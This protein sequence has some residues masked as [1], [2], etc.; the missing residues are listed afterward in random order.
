MD[1]PVRVVGDEAGNVIN[2]SS[3]PEYGYVRLEQVKSVIDD[4]GFL[5]R[6]TRS[7]LVQGTIDELK[8]AGFYAGQTLPGKIVILESLEPFNQKD[9][10]RDLKIA[11]STGI[12]CTQ[13][14][15]PIY[16]KS[17]YTERANM[18]DVP[19]DHDNIDELRA[20]YEA[21]KSNSTAIQPN[22]EFEV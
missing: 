1:T 10:S 6:K 21:A 19:V 18:E 17:L 4:N 7:A 20:A 14:G 16:R 9:P 3:N 13:G 8:A 2:T 5:R 12:P 15:Q 22:T 11:G